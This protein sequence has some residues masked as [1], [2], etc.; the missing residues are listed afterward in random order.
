MITPD[1]IAIT[2]NTTVKFIRSVFFKN[3]HVKMSTNNGVVL[4]AGP[5]TINSPFLKAA[6]IDICARLAEI[7]PNE[8][9]KTFLLDSPLAFFSSK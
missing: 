9:N 7:P 4:D 1:T 3:K 5:I 6:N 8:N 2:P